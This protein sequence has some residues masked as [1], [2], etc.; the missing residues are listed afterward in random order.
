[1]SRERLPSTQA[2]RFL[3]AHDIPFVP[4]LYRYKGGGAIA[5][6]EALGIEPVRVAKTLVFE[7]SDSE[8]LVVIMNGPFETSTKALA[9]DLGVK[10]VRPCSVPRAEALT[11]YRV[12]GISPFG[13]RAALPVYMQIDLF[14]HEA[15]LVNGGQRGF[16]VEIAPDIIERAL[17]AEIVDVALEPSR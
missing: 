1:M 9:R 2:L 8:P 7:T 12:G 17:S 10:A 13:Q 4:H 15:I 11:G 5:S 14:E 16:L 3:R 6:A